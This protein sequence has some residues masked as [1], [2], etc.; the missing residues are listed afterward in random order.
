MDI[1]NNVFIKKIEKKCEFIR[2]Q[3]SN[4]NLPLSEFEKKEI[5]NY[6]VK[7]VDNLYNGQVVRLNSIIENQTTLVF[8][9][10]KVRYFDSLSSNILYQKYAKQIEQ[11]QNNHTIEKKIKTILTQ[12]KNEGIGT[13]AE[14]LN[15]KKLANTIAVSVLVKDIDGKY[16]LVLR[17][18]NLAVGAGMLSVTV[19]GA[20][21]ENDYNCNNPVLACAKRELEEELGIS[22]INTK[23]EYIVISKSKL[24]PVF[25]INAEISDRWRDI[26]PNFENAKD[27]K[28]E[29]KEL[30]IVSKKDMVALM[31][32]CRMTDAA[33]FHLQDAISK[34]N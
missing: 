18:K 3:H 20:L 29:V 12:I 28:N 17:T 15:N 10:N 4:F 32:N 13:F 26:I 27:Y 11:L 31:Q 6:S 30:L 7:N 16:A 23:I 21:D 33:Y 19:T 2:E 22:T 8:Y 5:V 24:Q 1:N 25:I 34:L 14:V 9:I